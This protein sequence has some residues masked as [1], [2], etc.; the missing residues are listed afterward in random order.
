MLFRSND[1]SRD[2]EVVNQGV[3]DTGWALELEGDDSDEEDIV[4]C[5]RGARGFVRNQGCGSFQGGGS[6]QSLSSSVMHSTP[7]SSERSPPLPSAVPRRQ[8]KRSPAPKQSSAAS[9]G[10]FGE[11]HVN[12]G[13]GPA[14]QIPEIG[15]TFSEDNVGS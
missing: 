12:V 2:V 9:G 13:V 15:E 14:H 5:L 6:E 8:S 7:E 10:A 11:L 4:R 1:L 3:P